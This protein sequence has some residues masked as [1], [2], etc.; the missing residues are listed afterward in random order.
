MTTA[1]KLSMS[2][3][4]H[5]KLPTD[6]AWTPAMDAVGFDPRE[7]TMSPWDAVD[8]AIWE[9]LYRQPVGTW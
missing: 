3:G 6:W 9:W 7:A 5:P 4:W 2:V 8:G 1:L